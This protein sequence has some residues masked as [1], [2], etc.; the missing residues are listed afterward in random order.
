M[1]TKR[2]TG[3]FLLVVGVVLGFFIGGGLRLG[4]WEQ[5]SGNEAP[6]GASESVRTGGE[7][8]IRIPGRTGSI[9]VAISERALAEMS[10]AKTDRAIAV[11]ALGGDVFL[12]DNYTK[13]AVIDRKFG[14]RQVRI[15]EGQMVGK[16][17]WVPAE[18]IG[19]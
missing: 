18:W 6:A 14:I 17:G 3:I 16:I 5:Q 8:S 12:V 1:A 11:M 13:A 9:P 15:L 4:W 19:R 10:T 7:T 2:Q